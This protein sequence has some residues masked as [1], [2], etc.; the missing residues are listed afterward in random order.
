M[1]LIKTKIYYYHSL[2][3]FF[4]MK[5]NHIVIIFSEFFVRVVCETLF[6][7]TAVVVCL[8]CALIKLM[9]KLTFMQLL[10]LFTFMI[11]AFIYIAPPKQ[12]QQQQQPQS[13]K[14]NPNN[15][16][17]DITQTLQRL[18]HKLN[19]VLYKNN[20]TTETIVHIEHHHYHYHNNITNITTVTNTTNITLHNLT[21]EFERERHDYTL[22]TSGT[23][24]VRASATYCINKTHSSTPSSSTPPSISSPSS[25]KSSQCKNSPAHLLL[26]QERAKGE[27]WGMEGSN[28]FVVLG[29]REAIVPRAVAVVHPT[30]EGDGRGGGGGR[31]SSGS[32]Y[33]GAPRDFRVYGCESPDASGKVLLGSFMY[34]VMNPDVMQEFEL[35][36]QDR[37]FK[38]V[39]VEIVSNWG[40]PEWTCL[41][42]IKLY[43]NAY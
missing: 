16:T 25:S 30:R 29:L 20:S 7:I 39:L 10:F 11:S 8:E 34:D 35:R 1:I 31:S 19:S 4:K 27:C 36:R 26:G 23:Q 18:E 6:L 13:I 37:A 40:N 28:G 24:I 38:Y 17:T 15:R 9:K 32:A 2:L 22:A 41:Y 3:F 42:K 14:I 21:D 5:S 33:M 43:G 12:Q